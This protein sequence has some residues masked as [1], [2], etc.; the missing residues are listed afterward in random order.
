MKVGDKVV[1]IQTVTFRDQIGVV[2]NE[3]YII[4]DIS[5]CSCGRC[6]IDVGVVAQTVGG[7]CHVCKGI[8]NL[9]YRWLFDYSRFRPIN[10]TYGTELCEAI[11]TEFTKLKEPQPA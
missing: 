8:L 11:E 9:D 2:K 5:V 1:C 6:K 10:Y 3:I 7:M 4:K